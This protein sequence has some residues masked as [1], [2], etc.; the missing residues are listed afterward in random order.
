MAAASD[1]ASMFL[2]SARLV[3]LIPA[4]LLAELPDGLKERLVFDVAYNPPDF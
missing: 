1:V 4:G 2:S 3:N